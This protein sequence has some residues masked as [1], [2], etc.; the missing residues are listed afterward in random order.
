MISRAWTGP[1]ATLLHECSD[2]QT[3]FLERPEIKERSQYLY[4][5]DQCKDWRDILRQVRQWVNDPTHPFHQPGVD[6]LEY[7]HRR[8]QSSYPKMFS[9]TIHW[10]SEPRLFGII[11]GVLHAQ[12]YGD[13]FHLYPQSQYQHTLLK[14]LADDITAVTW[15]VHSGRLEALEWLIEAGVRF[16]TF[17]HFIHA[18]TF[19][20]GEWTMTKPMAQ[21]IHA[22]CPFLRMYFHTWSMSAPALLTWIE[23]GAISYEDAWNL[24]L[25]P[26]S[27]QDLVALIQHD[28]RFMLHVNLRDFC[29]S[30]KSWPNA[31]RL[32]YTKRHLCPAFQEIETESF[33]DH[34]GFHPESVQVALDFG[35]SPQIMRQLY[36]CAYHDATKWLISKDIVPEVRYWQKILLEESPNEHFDVLT[37]KF[38]HMLTGKD[39]YEILSW[40]VSRLTIYGS[41]ESIKNTIQA[42]TTLLHAGAGAIPQLQKVI[43]EFES[44]VRRMYTDHSICKDEFAQL[45]ELLRVRCMVT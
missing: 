2:V 35:I 8:E 30:G 21:F 3:L 18:H 5:L 14:E 6:S 4:Q 25:H 31:L 42:F 17:K 23:I 32:F 36:M 29:I 34:C 12:K 19:I 43:V 24:N 26:F 13:K 22:Q 7:W 40:V 11:H 16:D 38:A 9:E 1:L 45:F 20:I 39:T 33:W 37:T 28:V 10:M 44:N 27:D 15:V 41:K